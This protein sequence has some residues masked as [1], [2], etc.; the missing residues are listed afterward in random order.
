MKKFCEFLREHTIETIIFEK[1]KMAFLVEEQKESYEKA[2][3]CHI[4]KEN[5][6]NKYLDN[7]KYGKVRDHCHYIANLKMFS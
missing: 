4:C 2:N 7:K 1:K 5:F 3:I 6:E